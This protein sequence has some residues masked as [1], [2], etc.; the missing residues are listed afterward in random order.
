MTRAALDIAGA[1]TLAP[2]IHWRPGRSRDDWSRVSALTQAAL[3]SPSDDPAR[4]RWLADSLAFIGEDNKAA[5]IWARAVAQ[6]PDDVEL[7]LRL[8]RARLAVLDMDDARRQVDA[9]LALAPDNRQARLLRFN[10]MVRN[11][12]WDQAEGMIDEI[13]AAAPMNKSLCT[14]RLHAQAPRAAVEAQLAACEAALADNPIMTDAV[15]FKAI[16]LARLGRDEE[17]RAVLDLERFVDVRDL[18]APEGH[19]S[20]QNFRAAL[21]EEI[22][23]NPSLS[24][25]W[26]ATQGGLQTRQLRQP[27]ANLIET[28]LAQIAAAVDDFAARIS[29]M[30]DAFARARPRDAVLKSWAVIYGADGQ[31]HPHRHPEGWLSG[32]FYVTAPRAE[33]EAAYRGPM[34]LGM[35][36]K[37]YGLSHTPWGTREIEPVPG[38]FVMFPSYIPHGTRP[39]GLDGA[40]VIVAFDVVPATP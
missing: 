38:R 24:R 18:P 34:V 19:A 16:A 12:Q 2:A 39:T 20:A 23:R 14:A 21:A 32:T 30:P 3:Q 27:G 15:Y 7:R 26:K 13:A 40:R 5:D 31:Q 29:P 6:A 10:L 28:L 33:G 8:G 35:I 11:E 25:D 1:K 17:A 4:L 36:D 37:M 9:A 22:S